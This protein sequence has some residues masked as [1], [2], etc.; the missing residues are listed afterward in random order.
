MRW[1]D[2]EQR[3]ELRPEGERR[4]EW[5]S[6]LDPQTRH[7]SS[8]WDARQR[9]D[10]R[11]VSAAESRVQA[12]YA[13]DEARRQAWE[14]EHQEAS[15]RAREADAQFEKAAQRAQTI[16]LGLIHKVGSEWSRPLDPEWNEQLWAVLS[17]LDDVRAREEGAAWRV[18][19]LTDP[20]VSRLPKRLLAFQPLVDELKKLESACFCAERWRS[21]WVRNRGW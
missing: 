17:Q 6:F 16:H 12:A 18:R 9:Q 20:Y 2:A 1:N 15:R 4:R 11:E 14:R 10:F 19:R 3:R 8:Q 7:L 13:R 5:G 21:E